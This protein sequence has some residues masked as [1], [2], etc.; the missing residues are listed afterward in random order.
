MSH[1]QLWRQDDNGSEFLVGAWSTR[2]EADRQQG[3]LE[4]RGHKQ[5][6]FVVEVTREAIEA[7]EPAS[8]RRGVG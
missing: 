4:R 1:Y 5:T 3:E 7:S 6:Y 2:E 8:T